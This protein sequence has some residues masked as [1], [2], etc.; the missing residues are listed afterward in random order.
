MLLCSGLN[1][2]HPL[3]YLLYLQGEGPYFTDEET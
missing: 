1:A 3:S 2:L